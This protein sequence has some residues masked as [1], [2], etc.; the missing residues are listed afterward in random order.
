M[1]EKSIEL[2]HVSEINAVTG[3]VRGGCTPIGMKKQFPTVFHATVE[4]QETVCISGGKIGIQIELPVKDL[5][6]IT[7][8]QVAEIIVD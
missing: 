2:L 7:R 4:D 1:G 6:E 3:Y 8:G 5:L